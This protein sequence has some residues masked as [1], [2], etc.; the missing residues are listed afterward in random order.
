M[1]EAEQGW[2][3]QAVVKKACDGRFPKKAC[4]A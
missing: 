2:A 1:C 4:S 3:H